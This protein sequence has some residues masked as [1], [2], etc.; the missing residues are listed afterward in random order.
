[1]I[2]DGDNREG[3]ASMFQNPDNICVTE[4]YI[5]VQEDPN[6]Y[7]DETHDA[8]LYQY[9]IATGELKVAFELDHDRNGTGEDVYGGRDSR[10]GAWE[11]GALL[12]ISETVG[13]EDVFMLCVQPH[14][15]KKDEF[16]GVDG[17]SVRPNEKQ[18]SQVV[19]LQGL[20]R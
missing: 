20:P 6:G 10:F 5:Y 16:K 18:G 13:M 11:Y 19:V 8:Y 7:G 4:N 17:G 2:L 12:D 3:K 9:D 1:L 15:W 14:T